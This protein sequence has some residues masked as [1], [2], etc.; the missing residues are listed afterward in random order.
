[1]SKNNSREDTSCYLA[2]NESS[3]I[4]TK[5][6]IA[7]FENS[8]IQAIMLGSNLE[9]LLTDLQNLYPQLKFVQKFESK[10]SL[11]LVKKLENYI[12]NP[13]QN[14]LDFNLKLEGTEFQKLVWAEL[15]RIPYDSLCTYSDIARHIGRP[16]SAR[17]VANACGQNNIPII[18][19]CH[20]VIRSDG[21]Y[22]GYSSG[23]HIKETLIKIEQDV[24]SGRK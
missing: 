19:P 9:S 18:I 13:K 11:E 15:C 3:C 24:M 6:L 1:M 17:A 7:Y 14:Y 20:R 2:L 8:T 12:V 21:S 10:Q 22:G 16:K 4:G 23:K 5:I